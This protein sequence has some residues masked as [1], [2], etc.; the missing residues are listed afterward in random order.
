MIGLDLESEKFNNIHMKKNDQQL[1]PKS[2]SFHRPSWQIGFSTLN[3]LLV[4]T[5]TPSNRI[6]VQFPCKLSFLHLPLQ[7]CTCFSARNKSNLNFTFKIPK[8][9]SKSNLQT[10]AIIFPCSQSHLVYLSFQ[11]SHFAV[12]SLSLTSCHFLSPTW[13]FCSSILSKLANFSHLSNWYC[14][15]ILK[16][17]ISV[18]QFVR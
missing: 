10:N 17:I 7:R 18:P 1:L 3:Q 4:T 11:N 13:S 2:I 16:L 9:K 6:S 8:K 15:E 12:K 5:V 14:M